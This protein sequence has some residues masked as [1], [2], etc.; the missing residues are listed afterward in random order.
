METTYIKNTK[1]YAYRTS[2]LKEQLM[3]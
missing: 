2:Y 1:T 3:M